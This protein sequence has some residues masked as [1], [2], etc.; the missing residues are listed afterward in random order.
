MH[1]QTN[2]TTRNE[3]HGQAGAESLTFAA[4]RELNDSSPTPWIV[5]LGLYVALIPAAM[6]ALMICA[7][8]L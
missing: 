5:G 8:V 7:T 2:G 1:S 4:P 6:S 3:R